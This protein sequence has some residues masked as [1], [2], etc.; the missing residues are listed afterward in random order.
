MVFF[1]VFFFQLIVTSIQAIGIPGAGTWYCI[2]LLHFGIKV[3]EYLRA[4]EKIVFI[5]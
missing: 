5:F 4:N 3:F 1:F 2:F